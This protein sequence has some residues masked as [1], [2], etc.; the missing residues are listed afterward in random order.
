RGR[1]AVLDKWAPGT[2]CRIEAR[3]GLHRRGGPETAP[4]DHLGPSPHGRMK[5]VSLWW[6]TIFDEHAPRERRRVEAPARSSATAPDDHLGACPN[7]R[8]PLASRR[9]ASGGDEVP[10]PGGRVVAPAVLYGV[11][12]R[13][14]D[15]A[16]PDDHVGPRPHGGVAGAPVGR[17]VVL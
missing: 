17:C 8:V 9:R 14:A 6:G 15:V 3:A 2:G 5:V 11:G 13:K 1:R 7:G 4:D 16:A 10:R 12:R